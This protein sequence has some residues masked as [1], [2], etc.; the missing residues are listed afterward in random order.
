MVE[1]NVTDGARVVLVEDLIFNGG[2]KVNFING[3]RMAG[4]TVNH[5]FTIASYGFSEEY[6]NTLGSIGSEGILAYRLA[7]YSSGCRKHRIL[8]S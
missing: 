5:V 7:Y 2:S 4:L 8:Q 3:L 1:G 6:E